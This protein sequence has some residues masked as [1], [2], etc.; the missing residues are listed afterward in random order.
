MVYG[1][2]KPNA[3]ICLES[4]IPELDISGPDGQ[5]DCRVDFYDF[6]EFAES[7]LECTLIPPSSCY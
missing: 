2:F 7:W 6:A 4:Q 3:A 5:P 1:E